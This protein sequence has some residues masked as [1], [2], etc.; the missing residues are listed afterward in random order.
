MWHVGLE[1][2]V[3]FDKDLFGRL[4]IENM[5]KTWFKSVTI[6]FCFIREGRQESIFKII[7]FKRNSAL[8]L[9]LRNVTK[10][11][12]NLPLDFK[13][14]LDWLYNIKTINFPKVIT[15]LKYYL[16]AIDSKVGFS[17]ENKYL[18][19]SCFL[20]NEISI[21]CQ[22]PMLYL[23]MKIWQ[24]TFLAQKSRKSYMLTWGSQSIPMGSSF[25]WLGHYFLWLSVKNLKQ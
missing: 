3:C 25:V 17:L 5:K 6:R 4:K 21:E 2:P 23:Q 11:I 1:H 10:T 13:K 15:N 12:K 14:I 16:F 22:K 24:I 9:L 7:I 18:E 19:L 20:G 8:Y